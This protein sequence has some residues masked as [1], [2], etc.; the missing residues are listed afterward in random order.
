MRPAFSMRLCDVDVCDPR[1]AGKSG[2][3]LQVAELADQS[4]GNTA[5]YAPG[6]AGFQ[7][8]RL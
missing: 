4:I 2:S 7:H 5:G 8:H 1:L 6:W 3:L